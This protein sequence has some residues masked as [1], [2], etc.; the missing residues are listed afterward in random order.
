MKHD[1]LFL[2]IDGLGRAPQSFWTIADEFQAL[3]PTWF[4]GRS[5]H[6]KNDFWDWC[7]EFYAFGLPIHYVGHSLG[8]SIVSALSQWTPLTRVCTID[9]VHPDWIGDLLSGDKSS[10]E[11]IRVRLRPGGSACSFY[12]KQG[13]NNRLM[14]GVP[15]ADWPALEVDAGHNEIIGHVADAVLQFLTC[16]SPTQSTSD[17]QPAL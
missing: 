10:M 13:R 2:A 5:S 6:E 1:G 17:P 11:R 7:E 9:A 8:G 4:V 16:R 15:I 3:H 12:R 14:P